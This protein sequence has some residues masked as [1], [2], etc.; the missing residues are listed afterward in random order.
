MRVGVCRSFEILQE[1]LMRNLIFLSAS[2]LLH[3]S[4]ERCIMMLSFNFDR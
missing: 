4:M 2:R 3:F 1:S